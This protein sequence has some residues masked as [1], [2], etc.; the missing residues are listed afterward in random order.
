M[1]LT[2]VLILLALIVVGLVVFVCSALAQGFLE[3]KLAPREPMFICAVHGPMAEK[4]T[5][6]F[7][8][9]DGVYVNPATKQEETR[10]GD[11]RYCAI[12]FHERLKAAERIG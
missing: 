1:I 11:H 9:Y 12:C 5:L 8:N 3:T 2:Y 7:Q 6:L 10:R 4:N